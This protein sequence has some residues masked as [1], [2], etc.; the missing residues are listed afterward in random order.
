MIPSEK[1]E[2]Y[3]CD[4]FN[5]LVEVDEENKTATSTTLYTYDSLGNLTNITDASGNVRN[6]TYDG[7]SREL[8]AQDL[9]AATDTT[10]G[11][12]NYSY[13]DQG[14]LAS[15]TDAKGQTI[16]HTYDA[17]NRVLTEDYTGQTG[18]R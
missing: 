5:D 10:F 2:S 14:N 15:T 3:I 4:A 18:M 12:W 13:D 9:H 1:F 6:F 7:L 16:L 11:I 17:L 8:T